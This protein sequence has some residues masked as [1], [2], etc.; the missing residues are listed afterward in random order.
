MLTWLPTAHGPH[1]RVRVLLVEDDAD[2]QLI[3]HTL[4]R[5]IADE[6]E[7]TVCDRLEA[8]MEPL[9]RGLADVVLLD[10]ALPDA[11]G[12]DGLRRLRAAAPEVP[13]VVLSGMRDERVAVHAVQAGA[14]DFLTKGSVDAAGLSRAM[15]YA[16]ER[17]RAEQRLTRMA[18]RDPLT[19]LP[20]RALFADRLEQALARRRRVHEGLRLALLF[21]DLNEFKVVNDR[22]GHLVGDELLVEVGQRLR[23][24]LRGADTV[25]RLGGDE[26]T[27]LAED[28]A[29][30]EEA[31][32]LARRIVVSLGRPYAV[33]GVSVEMSAAVGITL[34]AASGE[35]PAALLQ[36]ADEA[37]YKAKAA[38]PG[39][40]VLSEDHG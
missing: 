25:A 4:L 9:T 5:D 29:G 40:A 18:L 21:I 6:C 1:R 19:G 27:V 22:Y 10:L 12:L 24:E 26:F 31:R 11:Q 34:A 33:G 14:Q 15:R 37:M 36:R 30:P 38:G 3:V 39:I 20:N 35:G 17:Q 23:A 16:L 7:L 2:D 32:A 13:V 8:A 28:V